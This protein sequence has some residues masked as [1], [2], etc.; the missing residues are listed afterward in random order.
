MAVQGDAFIL[1]LRDNAEYDDEDPG[2]VDAEAGDFRLRPDAPVL[3]TGFHPLAV[4]QM[5]LYADVL[6]PTWPVDTASTHRRIQHK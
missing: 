2:F 5:G 3:A 6:R 1:D 4:E